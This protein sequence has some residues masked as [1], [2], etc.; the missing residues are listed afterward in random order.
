MVEPAAE[1]QGTRSN[2]P[3]PE[4]RE[5]LKQVK[6]LENQ[7][8]EFEGADACLN[9]APRLRARTARQ[10]CGTSTATMDSPAISEATVK[11]ELPDGTCMHTAAEAEGPVDALNYAL[12]KALEGTYPELKDVRLDDYKVRILNAQAATAAMTRVLIESSDGSAV[13]NTVGVSGNIVA[14]SYRALVDSIEYKLLVAGARIDW[15]GSRSR[16]PLNRSLVFPGSRRCP[17]IA[18]STRLKEG[19]CYSLRQVCRKPAGFCEG[20]TMRTGRV[21]DSGGGVCWGFRGGTAGIARRGRRQLADGFAFTEGPAADAAGNVYFTDQP[22]DRI[23]KWSVDGELTTYLQPCGRSNGLCFDREGHLWACADE[24]NQLWRI[25]PGKDVTVLIE[26][27]EGK[28]L[29]GPNDLWLRPDG[30]AYFTDPF[31]KREYWARGETMEQS[32]QGVYYL[33]PDRKT[34]ARVIDDL[35]QPNGIIGTPDGKTLYVTDIKAGKTYAYTILADGSLTG[36]T[37]F[38]EMGSDGMTRQ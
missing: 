3:Q 30:G 11:I 6:E 1:S 18:R 22:N 2:G 14:A 16:R 21:L 36:K 23:M 19:L 13:W 28:L 15:A 31:Y 25:S 27:H 29:N 5:A 4:T 26:T 12:R 37:L 9:P 32:C 17:A 10:L 34:L 24:K 7:G 38:C 33:A 20:D 8:Y 35:D